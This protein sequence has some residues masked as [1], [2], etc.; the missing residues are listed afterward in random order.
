MRAPPRGLPTPAVP[1]GPSSCPRSPLSPS[2]ERPP[3]GPLFPGARPALLPKPSCQASAPLG[4][5]GACGVTSLGEPSKDPKRRTPRKS[6]AKGPVSVTSVACGQAV[7]EVWGGGSLGPRHPRFAPGGSL[8]EGPGGACS[9][10]RSDGSTSEE[11]GSQPEGGGGTSAPS[12][13]S[14]S[15]QRP[16]HLGAGETEGCGLRPSTAGSSPPLGPGYPVSLQGPKGR[17]RPPLGGLSCEGGHPPQAA[18]RAAR[19]GAGASSLVTGGL[20]L[21]WKRAPYRP[22]A[23]LPRPTASTP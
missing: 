17:A 2:P 8:R 14:P 11:A 7:L 16:S 23:R 13:C 19:A 12:T 15:G 3:A 10:L 18:R 5:K 22:G 21:S 6:S 9:V 20:R 1:R 4:R